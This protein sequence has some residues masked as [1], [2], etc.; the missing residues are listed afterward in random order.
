MTDF[1]DK[2]IKMD[3]ETDEDFDLLDETI[4]VYFFVDE[5]GAT[6]CE[7]AYYEIMLRF[8]EKTRT[9]TRIE[10]DED[11]EGEGE[12]IEMEVA[13]ERFRDCLPFDLL[14]EIRF[15]QD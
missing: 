14:E 12:D 8:D 2:F 5:T 9:W 6:I 13:L 11:K 10:F 4:N 1:S 7:D 15:S 3:P